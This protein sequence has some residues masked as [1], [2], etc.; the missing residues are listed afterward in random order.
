M[1]S[2]LAILRTLI[3]ISAVLGLLSYALA[4]LLTVADIIGRQIGLPVIGVVD[5]VQL[6]VLSG[7]WLVIPYAFMTGAHVGVD[8]LIDA[9]P[10][11]VRRPLRIVASLAAAGLLVLILVKSYDTFQQQMM[12]GDRSQQL[13]IP[14]SWYWIPLLVGAAASIPAALLVLLSDPRRKPLQ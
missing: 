1:S 13:G 4:V 10:A 14:I 6:F 2:L 5:L 11:A 12:F 8:L 7:A 3:S 9:L